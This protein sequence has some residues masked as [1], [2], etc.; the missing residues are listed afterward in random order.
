[1]LIS[2]KKDTTNQKQK[3][4]SKKEKKHTRLGDCG[5]QSL[6]HEVFISAFYYVPE[7]GF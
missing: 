1:M 3:K 4:A 5:R 7:N 2:L 6:R